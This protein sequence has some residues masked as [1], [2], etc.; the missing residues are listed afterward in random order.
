MRS[1]VT[2]IV[3]F[4]LFLA[5]NN[6]VIAQVVNM[7]YPITNGWGGAS[8]N[9][10]ENDSGYFMVGAYLSLTTGRQNMRSLQTDFEGNVLSQ[11]IISDSI[12]SFSPGFQGSLIKVSGGYVVYG[13]KQNSTTSNVDGYLV[14]FNN[15][16]DTLWTRLFGDTTF[17]Q[18]GSQ[19]KETPDGGF[20]CIAQNTKNSGQ[21]WLVKTDSLGN[22]EWENWYGTGLERPTAIAVCTDSGYICTGWTNSLG[23]GTP[24]KTNIRITKLDKLG[25]AQWTKIFGQADDDNAWSIT[26]TQDGGYIF[27]GS[28]TLTSNS[29]T[30][31]YAIRL[32][33]QGDTVW[34][35]YYPAAIGTL[36][37]G[38]LNSFKT[39]IELP[40]GNF[41]AAGEEWDTDGVTFG[42]RDGLIIKLKPNGD[43]L[44]HKT[45]RI[46]WMS[47]NNQTS[48]EIK[49]IR[50]TSDGGFIC[51]GVVYPAFPD[52][53]TQDM[54]L[55][56]I[57][58]NG[59]VDTS[60]CSIVTAID[61]L[62]PSPLGRDGVGLYPNPNNGLFTLK[63]PK[64]NTPTTLTLYDYT[65]KQILQHV[66]S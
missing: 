4:C 29:F 30:H 10:V 59:C 40:D 18:A 63:L 13:G 25:N 9:A 16:G 37:N 56:K 22:M 34:T 8:L 20:I 53:G 49:D 43:T 7:R 5:L 64:L 14:K 24:N 66:L 12:Y 51:G 27:G 38:P 15:Q 54:W 50:P 44:W 46:P 48:F 41:I 3:L 33:S 35:R 26:Q 60:N 11:K 36:G 1:L 55:M 19:V 23:V 62:I 2:Y 6:N 47:S 65:G 52:T 39:I 31:P 28:I 45:Y 17:F 32:N 61:E 42:H 57:D 21:N 58:S